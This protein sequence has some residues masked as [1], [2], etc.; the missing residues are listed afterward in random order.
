MFFF[1]S[2]TFRDFYSIKVCLSLVDEEKYIVR[3]KEQ[4]SLTEMIL[5]QRPAKRR[6]LSDWRSSLKKHYD[7]FC[8]I[9]FAESNEFTRN[10]W[11]RTDRLLPFAAN[12]LILMCVYSSLASP[13][14]TYQAGGAID[15]DG[16]SILDR[17][18]WS[19]GDFEFFL[20][21]GKFIGTRKFDGW[22]M[23]K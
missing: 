13:I 8:F 14:N 7:S 10:F 19:D 1:R 20:E 18:C 23:V 3:C 22:H 9:A 2:A 21:P 11:S 5:S 16:G 15:L 12:F 4:I 17:V 6:S